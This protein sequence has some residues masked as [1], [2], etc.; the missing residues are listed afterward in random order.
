MA[1]LL[2]I[3][4]LVGANSAAD[5]VVNNNT[6][7]KNIDDWMKDNTT[8]KGDN[9][10]FNVTNYEL[11]DTI[12]VSKSINVKSNSKTQIIFNKNKNM[13]NITVNNAD[14]INF[15]GLTLQ[16]MEKEIL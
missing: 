10:V 12:N 9:L 6:T 3:F 7:H 1:S 13:F 2:L 8:V 4:G 15:S 14:K 5:L 11:T 16:Q